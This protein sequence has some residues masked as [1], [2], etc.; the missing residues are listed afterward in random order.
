MSGKEDNEVMKMLKK[1]LDQ[2][3]IKLTT[4]FCEATLEFPNGDK[5]TFEADGCEETKLLLKASVSVEFSGIV[6]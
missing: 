6:R 1:A 2:R 5:F 4:Q 3:G